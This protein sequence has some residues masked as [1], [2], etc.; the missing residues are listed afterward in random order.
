MF[1]LIVKVPFVD[2]SAEDATLKAS[3]TEHA[4]LAN[5]WPCH[6]SELRKLLH[7]LFGWR[8]EQPNREVGC[9]SVF[10]VLFFLVRV[11]PLWRNEFFSL[12]PF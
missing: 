8:A 4:H 9:L 12:P 1:A 5:H 7:A 11:L 2:D 10:V 3:S 6:G